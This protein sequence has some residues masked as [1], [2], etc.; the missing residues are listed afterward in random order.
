MRDAA[1]GIERQ[2]AGGNAFENG[3]HLPAAL[4]QLG[5]GGS[6]V[7]AGGFD[8]PPAGFQFL[9]HA[10]ER[11]D[12][13]SDF[14]GSAYVDTVIQTPARDFLRR[15][16]KAASGRVTSFERNS[17]SHVVTNSTIIVS[18]RSKPM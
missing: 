12:E 11:T 17:A 1:A 9:R 15:F 7:A 10:I 4:V 13:I 14:V 3:L 8:L 5:I 16:A 18:S 6:R 2:D